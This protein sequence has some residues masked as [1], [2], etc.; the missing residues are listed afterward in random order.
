[1][2]LIE[3]KS[4][5]REVFDFQEVNLTQVKSVMESLDVNKATGHD[6]ISAR[7]LKALRKY[8]YHSLLFTI[9][10]LERVSGH[11]IG[12]KGTGLQSIKKMTGMLRTITDQ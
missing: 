8:L 3:E 6:G 12:R 11:V 2:Q 7:I 4:R 5:G 9:C 1:M 10:A